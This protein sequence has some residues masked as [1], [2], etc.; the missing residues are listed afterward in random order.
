VAAK[1]SYYSAQFA[2]TSASMKDT[3]RIISKIMNVS[4]RASLPPSFATCAGDVSDPIIIANEFNNYF[5]NVGIS[6]SN[7]IGK[8]HVSIFDSLPPSCAHSAFFEG[9]DHKEV[10]RIIKTLKSTMS[11]GVD[12]ISISVIMF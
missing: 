8:T 7:Q 9:T 2:L 12:D 10:L 1:R 4:P 5:S 3:W 6:L 11:V